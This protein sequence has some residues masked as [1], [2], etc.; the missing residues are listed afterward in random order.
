MKSQKILIVYGLIGGGITVLGFFLW[1]V[2]MNI[3]GKETTDM[4]AGEI[5][6]YIAMLVALSMVFFGLRS[7]RREKGGRISFKSA[8]FN[9]LIIVAIASV[10]Y[11]LGWMVYYPNFYPEFADQYLQGQI[12][13][14][15]ALD[16]GEEETARRIAELEAF[17]EEYK[18]PH[19]MAGYTFMEIFP[20]GLIVALISALILRSKKGD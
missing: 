8:F 20:V 4:A 10:I 15:R 14:V 12:A 13:A 3:I 1:P 7:F 19:I 16:L 17:T 2:L 5:I 11:V 9:G 18:K 6:G